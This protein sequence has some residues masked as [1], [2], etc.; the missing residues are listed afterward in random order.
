MNITK[1]F[2]VVL[3]VEAPYE[4]STEDVALWIDSA[5]GRT[6]TVESEVFDNFNGLYDLET[7]EHDECTRHEWQS[8]HYGVAEDD[9][10]YLA[11]TDARCSRCGKTKQQLKRNAQTPLGLGA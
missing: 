5:L 3:E 6:R 4:G 8:Y 2:Y 10:P 11:V 7:I 9:M 1:R